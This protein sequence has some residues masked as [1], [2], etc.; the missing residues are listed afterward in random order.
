MTIS[1]Q[2]P[3]QAAKD[4]LGALAIA[5]SQFPDVGV[6]DNMVINPAVPISVGVPSDRTQLRAVPR[7]QRRRPARSRSSNSTGW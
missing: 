2:I 6:V 4:R 1:G 7:G 3:S 5:N